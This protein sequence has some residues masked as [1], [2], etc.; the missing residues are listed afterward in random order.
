LSKITQR[1]ERSDKAFPRDVLLPTRVIEVKSGRAPQAHPGTAFTEA[2]KIR[3][4]LAMGADGIALAD[5]LA[6]PVGHWV[7]P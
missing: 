2:F 1:N 5:F 7:G 6:R 4:A 3:R